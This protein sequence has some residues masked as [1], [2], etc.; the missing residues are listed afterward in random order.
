MERR[1]KYLDKIYSTQEESSCE[2]DERSSIKKNLTRR[3]N[4]DEEEENSNQNNDAQST[5]IA[6]ETYLRQ[7]ENLIGNESPRNQAMDDTTINQT[8]RR[9]SFDM[10]QS[11][12]QFGFNDVDGDRHGEQQEIEGEDNDE[13]GE[14]MADV[15]SEQQDEDNNNQLQQQDGSESESESDQGAITMAKLASLKENENHRRKKLTKKLSSKTVN[16]VSKMTPGSSSKQKKTKLSVQIN[17]LRKS[18]NILIENQVHQRSKDDEPEDL[19]SNGINL[20]D[21]PGRT[22]TEYSLNILKELFSREELQTRKLPGNR[23]LKNLTNEQLTDKQLDSEKIDL[24][25]RR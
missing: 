9:S 1:A 25:K 19:E 13:Q 20:F 21:I 15:N 7:I 23:L 17:N 6:A 5:E 14:V 4:S 8:T 2:D 18:I 3:M 10:T 22:P 16:N 12:S 11:Q 24:L